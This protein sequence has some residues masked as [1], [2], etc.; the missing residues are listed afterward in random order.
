MAIGQTCPHLEA[1]QTAA[2]KLILHIIHLQVGVTE[3]SNWMHWSDFAICAGGFTVYELAYMGVPT[4]VATVSQTQVEVAQ[5]MHQI[6]FNHW[7]GMASNQSI[8]SLREEL[9]SMMQNQNR[10][11]RLIQVGQS[12]IDGNGICR[13]VDHIL[14]L[15]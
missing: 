4:I 3:I 12:K 14:N 15:L 8:E 10:R 7:I 9:I 6:N 1:I 2:N 5:E 11:Q 13:T